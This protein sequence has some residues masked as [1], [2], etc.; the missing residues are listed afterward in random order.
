MTPVDQE[1]NNGEIQQAILRAK[2]EWEATFDSISDL[3]IITDANGT[4]QRMNRATI[5]KIKTSYSDLLGKNIDSLFAD[6]IPNLIVG[7]Q[8][9]AECKLSGF[10]EDYQ[11]YCFY[12]DTGDE[13]Q[14][15][16]YTLHDITHRKIAE[17]Q[18]IQEKQ[19]F[20]SLFSNSPAAIVT[21]D[22][23]DNITN[24][25][26]AFEELFDYSRDEVVG[27]NLDN[28]IAAGRK[29]EAIDFTNQTKAGSPIHGYTTRYCKDGKPIEV[30]ISGVPVVV[31]DKKV[32]VLAIYHDISVVMEAKRAA[33]AADKA[34]SEFLANMSHEIRTPMNGVIGMIELLKDTPLNTEQKDYLT[35]AYESAESLLSLINEILDFAK[36]ESGQMT[37]EKIDFDIRSMVEGVARTL[38]T[39]AEAKGLEMVCMVNRDVPSRVKGDPTRLRQILVN[40]VGNAIKFTTQGEIVIRAMADESTADHTRLLF[41]ISDTGIGIPREQQSVI[42]ERFV[43][44]DSSSTRKYGGSGLGLAISTELVKLMGG[45]IGVQS[46]PGKGSTF[47]FTIVTDKPTEEGTRP[48][49]IPMDLKDVPILVVDDNKTNRL[50]LTKIVK[51]FGCDVHQASSGFEALT[52]LRKKSSIGDPVRLVLLDMQMPEMD[53]EQVLKE[54]KT[55]PNLSA[56]KV[57]IL[58]SMGHRGDAVRLEVMGCS[59]YLL[60]PVR[61]K[62]LFN[63]ILTVLGQQP[64]ES[65]KNTGSLITKHILEET[66]RGVNSILLAEDNPINQMLALRLLQKVG[67]SVDVVETGKQAVEAVQRKEYRIVLMDVQ[68]PE[69]DGYE[70]TRQIRDLKGDI[71]KIPIIAMTAYAMAGDREKCLEAG[72]DDY[73]PKPLNVDETLELIKKYVSGYSAEDRMAQAKRASGL[74]PKI[75]LYDLITALPRFGDDKTTFYEFLGAFITHLKKSTYELEA[76]IGS[77]DVGKVHF[78]SHSIKG[79]SANFEI[80]SIREPAFEIETITQSGSLVGCEDLLNQIKSIIPVLEKDYRQNLPPTGKR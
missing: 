5:N 27:K 18:I 9:G 78:L 3:L 24:C 36:I 39:R 19:Y 21:L 42:F 45:E 44:V 41:S 40:L 13:S 72:M 62:E 52:T 7:D 17:K 46:E 12:V 75:P 4:I 38:S 76:A 79:A 69:M 47:W 11:I 61:Q 66:E 29:E 6:P 73:I 49:V 23:E 14:K 20:E 63:T 35:T 54:I 16:F 28:L 68:M 15:I 32:G 1:N 48:L 2:K 34:K 31:D 10:E 80:R 22:L 8:A 65:K 77:G 57:I 25:N 51:G 50:I 30:E 60:K 59:A 33:E 56:T 71:S 55:D 37:I 64:V 43:Q 26:P 74:R 58:T 70:A 67:Y 53:G